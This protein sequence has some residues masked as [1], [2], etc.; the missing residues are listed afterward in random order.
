MYIGVN[1]LSRLMCLVQ[2]SVSGSGMALSSVWMMAAP[3]R[4]M[5]LSFPVFMV[6]FPAEPHSEAVSL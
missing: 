3:L 2:S 4:F 5:L 6:S 1:D